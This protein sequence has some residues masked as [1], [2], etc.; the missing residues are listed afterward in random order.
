MSKTGR[1]WVL[2][3]SIYAAN[4]NFMQL[5][6]GSDNGTLPGVVGE[7]KAVKRTYFGKTTITA[8]IGNLVVIFKGSR[9]GY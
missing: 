9:Y 1:Y 4:V 7:T 6:A 5:L 8:N 3:L 2:L